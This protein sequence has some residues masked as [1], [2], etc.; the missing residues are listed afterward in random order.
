MGK[1]K[2]RTLDIAPLGEGTALQMW[3]A[4][5]RDFTVSPAHPYEFIVKIKDLI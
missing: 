3:H 1:G 2:D 4:L 5:S